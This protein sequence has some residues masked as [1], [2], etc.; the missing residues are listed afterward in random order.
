[1]QPKAVVTCNHFCNDGVAASYSAEPGPAASSAPG[2]FRATWIV[3]VAGRRR[4][5]AGSMPTPSELGSISTQ[6]EHGSELIV[7]HPIT[8]TFAD[9]ERESAF[10]SAAYRLAFPFHAFLM[11]LLIPLTVWAA[12]GAPSELLPVWYTRTCA[13]SIALVGRVLTHRIKDPVHSQRVGAWCWS[14]LVLLSCCVLDAY[15]FWATPATRCW[16]P[17]RE[18]WAAAR[19][20]TPLIYLGAALTNGTHGLGFRYKSVLLGLVLAVVISGTAAVCGTVMLVRLL[21]TTAAGTAGFVLAHIAELLLRRSVARHEE[22]LD[23]VDREKRRL[24]ERN[25]QLRAEKERLLYDNALQRRS[26]PSVTFE[27][28]ERS[29]IRRGLSAQPYHPAGDGPASE[30]SRTTSSASDKAGPRHPSGS[31]PASLPPGPPS[32]AASKSSSSSDSGGAPAAAG[33][34]SVTSSVNEHEHTDVAVL[35]DRHLL[36]LEVERWTDTSSLTSSQGALLADLASALVTQP[37]SS[38]PEQSEGEATAASG[39]AVQMKPEDTGGPGLGGEEPSQ[40]PVP[41]PGLL[42]PPYLMAPLLP[43]ATQQLVMPGTMPYTMVTQDT[44]NV[45]ST[46]SQVGPSCWSV[47]GPSCSN[48]YSNAHGPPVSLG[49]QSSTIASTPEQQALQAARDGMRAARDDIQRFYVLRT[50]ATALGASRPETGTISALH[51]VLLQLERPSLSCEEACESTGA[52][53][54]NFKKWRRR[55]H[56]ARLNVPSEY[57]VNSEAR[58]RMQ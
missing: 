13:T 6:S 46:L 57:R 8:G 34:A 29:V 17:L 20:A 26:R 44:A 12:H 48:V 54:S 21:F 9:P 3:A 22:K 55:V 11:A 36:E 5:T 38:A 42:R 18:S 16:Q 56:Q 32:S 25:E 39:R 47:V 50:L 4:V 41:D 33:S 37:S 23:A 7:M 2:G 51:S 30:S 1:M 28:D 14:A 45:N 27:D 40:G 43:T 19:E 58:H 31:P 35:G 49:S 53:M 10:R 52:S 24:E 15:A